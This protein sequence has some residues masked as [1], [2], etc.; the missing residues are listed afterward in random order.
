MRNLYAVGYEQCNYFS[1]HLI[2][3]A[4]STRKDDE[5]KVIVEVF[6]IDSYIMNAP[7]NRKK[8]PNSS[9]KLMTRNGAS[10]N[11]NGASISTSA[12]PPGPEVT[13]M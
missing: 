10:D 4:M 1:E 8:N 5:V 3:R 11:R 7:K 9:R 13:A 6:G 12:A 2:Q